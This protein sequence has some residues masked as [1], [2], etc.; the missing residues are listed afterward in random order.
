MSE[1]KGIITP[2]ITP[3]IKGDLDY[4]A[5][6][7]LI[8]FLEKVGVN[9]IFPMGSTGAFAITSVE[10]HVKIL[11]YFMD[12]KKENMYFLAGVGRNSFDETL[13]MG[14][15]A[16]E[17]G[18]DGLSI[19][20]PYYVNMS[21]ESL[22]TYYDKLLQEL[23]IPVLIYNIP[24]NTNNNISAETVFKL[25][26]EH[27][28]LVGIKDSSSN[29]SNF[30]AFIDV[31]GKDFVILQGQDDLLLPSLMMGAKGGI[32]GTSNFSDL[33]VKV[34]KEFSN[35]NIDKAKEIQ[36]KLS[37]LKRI[38]GKYEFPQAYI[39]AFSRLIYGKEMQNIFP[40]RDLDKETKEKL[41]GE[42]QPL[43]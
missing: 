1:L 31:L 38:M 8:E 29:F 39:A 13:T 11:E 28:N 30:S 34:Y 43:L 37:K 21:Q 22:F 12:K 42:I 23:D 18:V 35:N 16:K 6:D 5:V 2:T 41:L 33:T 27:S 25:K 17:L 10:L 7:S 40:L 15:Y 36:K 24:Q 14:N 9:G 19:V 32:C 3:I 4:D 26:K 20:T